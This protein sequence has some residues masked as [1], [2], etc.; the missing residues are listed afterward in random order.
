MDNLSNTFNKYRKIFHNWGIETVGMEKLCPEYWTEITDAF[1]LMYYKFPILH[2]S[3]KIVKI[4]D[5]NDLKEVLSD[6]DIPDK[7]LFGCVRFPSGKTQ[8]YDII[9]NQT[10]YLGKNILRKKSCDK[11]NAKGYKKQINAVNSVKGHMIH[12]II[13]V[14]EILLTAKIN[15]LSF[16]YLSESDFQFRNNFD[17]LCFQTSALEIERKIFEPIYNDTFSNIKKNNPSILG[18]FQY[19]KNSLR[20]YMAEMIAHYFTINDPIPQATAFYQSLLN[21]CNDYGILVNL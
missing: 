2:N 1:S 7:Y 16:E 10:I 19:S 13:H 9:Y 11:I 14:L 4:I 21:F 17:F 15:S 8:N 12:E 20:E 6:L 3:I 18:P 5:K